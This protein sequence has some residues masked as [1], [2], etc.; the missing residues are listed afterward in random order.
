MRTDN[1]GW[2]KHNETYFVPAGGAALQ[3]LLQAIVATTV[4]PGVIILEYGTHFI[5][6]V[7]ATTI[8]Q[9][10]TIIGNDATIYFNNTNANCCLYFSGKC[11]L[12]DIRFSGPNPGW[13][14]SYMVRISGAYSTVKGCI[15]QGAPNA[16]GSCLLYMDA[17]YCVTDGC[18]FIP[19]AVAG[20]ASI[21]YCINHPASGS[22]HHIRSCFFENTYSISGSIYTAASYVKISEC[23]IYCNNAVGCAQ[24]TFD[25]AS[26]ACVVMNC[27]IDLDA[28]STGRCINIIL[29][30]TGG[31]HHIFNNDFQESA[32]A[33]T[34]RPSVIYC[35]QR[36]CWI[37]NNNIISGN[38]DH[39]GTPDTNM[40]RAHLYIAAHYVSV[41]NNTFNMGGTAQLGITVER[42]G[43]AAGTVAME[44]P[45]IEGNF[46]YNID[47]NT[48]GRQGFGIHVRSDAVYRPRRGIIS[49]NKFV[50][51]SA[52]NSYAINTLAGGNGADSWVVTGNAVLTVTGFSQGDW[53]TGAQEVIANNQAP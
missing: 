18:S 40:D 52:V 10:L 51:D 19:T 20:A 37:N 1:G 16:A 31:R 2:I 17:S 14:A 26:Y 46:F 12:Q 5:S 44:G 32:S 33:T 28:A 23:L 7:A 30:D 11:T 24:I 6:W 13:L 45:I 9:S 21:D 36:Y 38:R 22:Q 27:V 35:G 3:N 29:S 39:G 49:D 41:Q 53:T 47:G 42:T 43:N 15:F 48:A 25:T 50:A 8:P 4:D 34:S